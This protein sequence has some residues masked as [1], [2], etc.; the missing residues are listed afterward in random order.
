M[1][2]ALQIY[3]RNDAYFVQALT[4]IKLSIVATILAFYTITFNSKTEAK[5]FNMVRYKK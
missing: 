3:S 2:E 1:K 5:L 4:D